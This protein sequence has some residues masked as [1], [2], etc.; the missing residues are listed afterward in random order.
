[1]EGALRQTHGAARQRSRVVLIALALVAVAVVVA[2]S[3]AASRIGAPR[4]A[5]S[6]EV[7][8]ADRDDGGTARLALD[9]SLIV[10]LT[11]NPSTGFAWSVSE[12]SGRGLVLTGPP[13]YLPG[14]AT[15]PVVGAAGTE[16]FTFRAVESGTFQVVLEYRRSFEPNEPPARTFRVTVAID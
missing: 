13:A 11:S 7:Q 10:A 15:A 9:G 1:M 6:N 4:T 16:V 8:L 2:L 14:G 12:R 5:P 3:F